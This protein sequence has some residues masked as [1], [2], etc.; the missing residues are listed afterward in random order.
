M[1]LVSQQQIPLG[2]TSFIKLLF[3]IYISQ[4][5]RLFIVAALSLLHPYVGIFNINASG[6]DLRSLHILHTGRC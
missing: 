6:Q 5:L 3:N 1:H 2:L 4:W